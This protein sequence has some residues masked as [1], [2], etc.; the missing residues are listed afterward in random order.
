METFT[1]PSTDGT[2]YIMKAKLLH[3]VR[4]QLRDGAFFEVIIW[5]VPTPLRGSAHSFK[6]RMAL[7]VEGICV[8]R[9][10]NEAGKGDHKH[11]GTNETA[12]EFGGI[13]KL[14]DDFMADVKGWLDEN[15]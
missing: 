3:R 14:L 7:V 11:W 8:M 1:S 15:S 6:Y 9:Y 12:Y 13:D 5:Q 2:N 4:R 10:D